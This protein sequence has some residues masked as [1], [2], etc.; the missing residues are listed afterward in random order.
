[1]V[2]YLKHHVIHR[3]R[4]PSSRGMAALGNPPDV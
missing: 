3:L 4:A 2:V 1:M